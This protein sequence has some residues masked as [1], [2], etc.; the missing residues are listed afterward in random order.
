M[1]TLENIEVQK[2][3]FGDPDALHEFMKQDKAN[4]MV[5]QNSFVAPPRTDISELKTGAKYLIIG[6][7]GSGKTTLLLYLMR[8]EVAEY[9]RL[10]LFKSNIRH[11]D[12]N[13]LDKLAKM[14]FVEG[15]GS[16]SMDTDYRTIWEWYLLKNF[17][18][19][20]DDSDVIEGKDIFRDIALLLEA[21]KDKFSALFE[22]VKVEGARGNIKLKF[23]TGILQTEIGAEINARKVSG[24]E[25]A[26]LDLVRLVQDALHKVKLKPEVKCRLYFDEL[27]FSLEKDGTGERDRRMVRDLIFAIYST[28]L[29]FQQCNIDV[30]YYAAVR[31][32]VLQSFPGSSQEVGKITRAFGA[33][34]SWEPQ[35]DQRSTILDIFENKIIRSEIEETGGFQDDALTKYFPKEVAG[36]QFSKYILDQGGH[37]PRGVLLC[38]LAAV[39][40]AWGA[41]KFEAKHFADDDNSFGIAMLDEYKE[42]LSATMFEE[43]VE[44]TLSLLR[45]KSSVFSLQDFR[46]RMIEHN[47]NVNKRVFDVDNDA[48]KHL[49]ILYRVGAIGNA[50]F[51][52]DNFPRQTWANRGYPTPL[53]DKQFV[54]HVAIQKVLQ[55]T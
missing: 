34:L 30:L 8:G 37:R 5:L 12:R 22:S 33:S 1:I 9:S 43:E 51:T 45:G 10:V 52:S 19:L 6:P 27:E 25:I 53:L 47:S 24:D 32:E 46:A 40:R 29:L 3:R 21:N 38:L 48:S 26:L 54:V 36:K 7:K 18:R 44:L 16:Y 23:D 28:N 2:I 11:E 55:T 49:S 20:L 41:K 42:E 31:S 50:Y 35:N 17:L 13:N 4:S 39:E 14:I 15:V